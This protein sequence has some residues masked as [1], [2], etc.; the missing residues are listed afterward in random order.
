MSAIDLLVQSQHDALYTFFVATEMNSTDSLPLHNWFEGD[1]AGASPDARYCNFTG[2]DC[3]E[4]LLVRAL[5]L[6]QTGLAGSLPETFGDLFRLVRFRAFNNSIRG[7]IPQGLAEIKGL[8]TLNLGHNAFSG[9]LPDFSGSSLVNLILDRNG[10]EG[11]VPESLCT[12]ENLGAF[13]VSGSTKLRGSLPSC[14]GELSTLVKLR[15]SD[16]GLTGNVPAKLCG[17]R[18]MNG[19]LNNTFGCDAVGCAA[20][21]FQRP[22]GRQ[23]N[24]D[25][26]CENCDVPSNVIGA[27][28]CQWYHLLPRQ[29]P[30]D[31]AT[32]LETMSPSP[33]PS[34]PVPPRDSIDGIVQPSNQ[35][36]SARSKGI[37][38]GSLI[39]GAIVFI[40][41]GAAVIWKSRSQRAAKLHDTAS[42]WGCQGVDTDELGTSGSDPAE[43][44]ATKTRAPTRYY[45]KGDTLEKN[46]ASTVGGPKRAFIP[47][48][49][50][51]ATKGATTPST[52][53]RTAR[54]VRFQLPEPLSWSSDSSEEDSAVAKK[55][56]HQ[57]ATLSNDADA[58]V[59]WIMNPVFDAAG[60]CSPSA[61]T[62]PSIQEPEEEIVVSPSNDSSANSLSPILPHDA[63]SSDLFLSTSSRQDNVREPTLGIQDLHSNFENDAV[64]LEVGKKPTESAR[65]ADTP[66]EP[67]LLH[68]VSSDHDA[69]TVGARLGCE[70]D[71]IVGEASEYCGPGMAEI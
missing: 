11:T 15:I 56:E 62:S 35:E 49:P 46:T 40:A 55:Q 29:T 57:P 32:G 61:C 22:F 65:D 36:R 39:A 6:N 52:R 19:L 10:F 24:P 5:D 1:M 70:D 37:I 68:Q 23:L 71:V 58:W 7:S 67:S 14:L 53:A 9:P 26:A 54:R 17:N 20:G 48:P 59:S 25:S 63:M 42:S 8:R 64:F 41:L 44:H 50:A 2:V 43:F 34:F 21:T 13:D 16:S 60:T 51:N 12:L 66:T 45:L 28:V 4:N 27:S 3:D 31:T 18:E 69:D 38:S 30:L 33:A 47:A